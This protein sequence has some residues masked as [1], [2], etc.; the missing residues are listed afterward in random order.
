[1]ANNR[2]AALL[3]EKFPNS[4]VQCHTCQWHCVI[5]P[6]KFGICH[7]RQNINGVLHVLNYGVVSSIAIDPIEKKPLFH[8]FPGTQVF[9]LG[10]WGCNFHCKHCQNWEISFTSSEKTT[11]MSQF[12]SP[13][14][15]IKSAK[16]YD[17]QGIA[18][19]YN[20]PT[21]WFEYTLAS[22]KLAKANG[23]YTVYVTNG[24]I[25][26][27]ALDAI[28]PYLDAYSVDI[29]GFSD[30]FYHQLTGVSHWQGILD[31]T[32]RAKEKW[33]MHVEVVTNIIPT[34]N[35]DRQQLKGIATWI[36][37]NLG[38]LTP[39]HITRFYPHNQLAYLPP[40]PIET[41]EQAYLLGQEAGLRF[42]YL[43]NV[44]GHD[45]ENTTCY[46]CGETIIKRVGYQ[47]QILGLGGSKC[48]F[49][50]SDLNM[51]MS[52]PKQE[53]TIIESNK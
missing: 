46:S 8:F 53:K 34:M 19:T 31:M 7:M 40:T 41:L 38:S 45:R 17:C 11:G 22:A 44:A 33:N 47:I 13:E 23:L 21:V 25:T 9:S 30:N 32:K 50:G 20:E 29:K 42:V 24:F 36:Y 10:T 28:G 6:D 49:C 52:T 5:S 51:V 37:D 26:S 18:W 35:D 43:G 39:W 48:K 14:D 16:G 2:Q 3:Y 27:D 4:Q 1:M 15:A 12:L